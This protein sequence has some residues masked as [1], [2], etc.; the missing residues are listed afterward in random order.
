MHVPQLAILQPELVTIR[1]VGEVLED[2]HDVDRAV[3]LVDD[4]AAVRVGRLAAVGRD[5]GLARVVGAAGARVRGA[6]EA[7]ARRAPGHRRRRVLV[8]PHVQV[9]VRR[10]AQRL[11]RVARR[12]GDHGPVLALRPVERLRG[13]EEPGARARH[14]KVDEVAAHVGGVV[15]DLR[16][17]YVGRCGAGCVV[18]DDE[19]C[20]GGAFDFVGDRVAVVD[21]EGVVD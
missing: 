14:E 7:R 8:A 18:R 1:R 19:L 21:F 13:V 3:R 20:V 12:L 9:R 5:A 4:V 10:R 6:L 2:A 17:D 15:P 16:P 11:A